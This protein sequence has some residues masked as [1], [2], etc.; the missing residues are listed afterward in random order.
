MVIPTPSLNANSTQIAGGVT[1]GECDEGKSLIETDEFT[2]EIGSEIMYAILACI[3]TV[4]V[5]RMCSSVYRSDS[6]NAVNDTTV[7]E[8]DT[9]VPEDDTT[10]PEDDTTVPE[11]DT[12]APEDDTTVPEDDTTVPEDD[13]T[14]PEDDTTVPEDDT[15][16]PEDDTTAPE[17]DTT[18]PED[19][20]TAPEDDTTA[21]EDIAT[22]PSNVPPAAIPSM[23]VE[24]SEDSGFKEGVSTT[25]G[26][27]SSSELNSDEPSEQTHKS[28]PA[29]VE[30]C[31]D[32][33]LRNSQDAL[34]TSKHGTHLVTPTQSPWQSTGIPP[35]DSPVASVKK[36]KRGT[37]KSA[38]KRQSLAPTA[39]PLPNA[40]PPNPGGA[41]AEEL[42]D[43][44]MMTSLHSP[45]SEP[46]DTWAEEMHD[47]DD[48][49][50]NVTSMESSEL[51]SGSEGLWAE[52]THE[53]HHKLTSPWESSQDQG[54]FT[55]TTTTNDGIV[56]A[57]TGIFDGGGAG[58]LITL[59]MFVME[60]Q[61]HPQPEMWYL[62]VQESEEGRNR[63]TKLVVDRIIW[64]STKWPH[65]AA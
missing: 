29:K 24:A 41:W 33:C 6:L 56:M 22:S 49:A 42:G 32:Q 5:A 46:D 31:D 1:D 38:T 63:P 62:P 11:D 4:V 25:R 59:Q 53:Y 55:A 47:D 35:Q 52:E 44:D 65:V 54:E 9:T 20:T 45:H 13:T 2:D 34:K 61:P 37:G 23:V 39:V 12:T 40:I 10:V 57:G 26:D 30:T 7:P 8:D 48:K 60:P 36:K 43:H 19:D 50:P 17:D 21:P 3:A 15:T 51:I 28:N 18:V 14:V 64:W 16:A 58:I 27:N